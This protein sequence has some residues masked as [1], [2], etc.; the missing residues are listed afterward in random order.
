MTKACK[1]SSHQGWV[2]AQQFFYE[3]WIWSRVLRAAIKLTLPRMLV[4][5]RSHF[6]LRK[7]ILFLNV[8]SVGLLSCILTEVE[9][10]IYNQQLN[11]HHTVLQ[12]HYLT[13]HISYEK[14]ACNGWLQLLGVKPLHLNHFIVALAII[15]W[16]AAFRKIIHDIVLIKYRNPCTV[17]PRYI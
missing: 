13:K 2:F 9:S 5:H 16:I 12:N 4:L 3:L 10:I 8:S 15:E 14:V 1:C 6:F 11:T 17:M 7:T